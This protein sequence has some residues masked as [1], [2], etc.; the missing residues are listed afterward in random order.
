MANRATYAC[1]ALLGTNKTGVIK[2]IDGGYYPLVL[3]AFN[4]YNSAGAFYPL[5]PAK[6][7]MESSGSLQRRIRN[8]ALRAEL[9]HPKKLPGMSDRQFLERVLSIY[10]DNV[11]AHIRSVTLLDGVK[12]PN[13][14]STVAVLGDV[15]PSGPHADVLKASLENPSENVCFSV[16]SL[17]DDETIGGR[18]FKHMRTIITWDYVNEP[19]IA[20]ANKFSAPTLEMLSELSFNLEQLRALDSRPHT[21]VSMESSPRVISAS[22]VE[23]AFG[24]RSGILAA[25]SKRSLRW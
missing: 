14:N 11:C 5:A 18:T 13:G 10:E 21:G 16:R 7:V 22:E 3:G 15:L 1:T 24:W 12:D 2:P 20:V 25:S 6:E 8:G 4:V 17:T 9:G 19:G 23:E